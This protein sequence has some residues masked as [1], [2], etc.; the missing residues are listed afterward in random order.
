VGN[1]TGKYWKDTYDSLLHLESDDVLNAS[2]QYVQDGY[3]NNTTIRVSTLGTEINNPSLIGTTTLSSPLS[4]TYGGLGVSLSDPNADRLL[5]WDDSAGNTAWLTL[6]TNLSITGTTLDATGGSGTGITWSEV[7]TT[8][9]AA[10][11]NSGYIV[12]NASLVTVTLPATFAVGEII[13]ISGKGAGLWRLAQNA[14]QQIHFHDISTTIGITGYLEATHR[15]D[16]IELIGCVANTELNVISSVGNI[17]Y[18]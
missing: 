7:T 2:L 14:S 8:S 3:G 13:R 6:G 15:R 16:A 17:T 4:L 10:D 1:L 9:Q 12:N 18:I 5:F 11:V